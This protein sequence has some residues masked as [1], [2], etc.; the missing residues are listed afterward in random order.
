MLLV[1]GLSFLSASIWNRRESPFS[2]PGQPISP[3]QLVFSLRHLHAFSCVGYFSLVMFGI[4]SASAQ[5]GGSAASKSCLVTVGNAIAGFNWS[6]TPT[7]NCP[8]TFPTCDCNFVF[9]CIMTASHFVSYIS[10]CARSTTFFLDSDVDMHSPYDHRTCVTN[11]TTATP[12]VCEIV[13]FWHPLDEV[14]A[15][16]KSINSSEDILQMQSHCR[17]IPLSSLHSFNPQSCLFTSLERFT[18]PCNTNAY[19]SRWPDIERSLLFPENLL[20]TRRSD[21]VLYSDVSLKSMDSSEHKARKQ[22]NLQADP[23][24]G[25]HF[26]HS[27]SRPQVSLERFYMPCNPNAYTWRWPDIEYSAMFPPGLLGTRYSNVL[28][29]WLL[30]FSISL[31]VACKA[32]AAARNLASPSRRRYCVSMLK[33]M[34]RAM[35]FLILSTS[36]VCVTGLSVSA[37]LTLV[38]LVAA[39]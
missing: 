24:A 11:A 35:L 21:V 12:A 17:V 28:H 38:L 2:N 7:I 31:L 1:A 22:K 33:V 32:Q 18:L 26:F 5:I 23:L 30:L 20:G 27:Q 16:L 6:N 36:P 25:M 14:D 19:I 10:V 39:V 29:A 13:S 34:M 8:S 4:G 37:P 9:E 15:S 3:F